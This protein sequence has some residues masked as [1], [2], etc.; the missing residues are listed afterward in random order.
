MTSFYLLSMFLVWLGTVKGA[1]DNKT[2][3]SP[4]LKI[5][6][7]CYPP[8]GCFKM[9][10][11][12]A[13]MK[14]L[15]QS[16]EQ[17]DTTF[18]LF[19][20]GQNHPEPLNFPPML[21]EQL[22]TSRQLYI[23]IHGFGHFP[24]WIVP[25]TEELLK[26]D[27]NVIVVDWT[28]GSRPPN[29]YQAASN[30]RVVGAMVAALVTDVLNSTSYTMKDITL[31]GFSLGCHV[32]GFAGKK[33]REP[34]L[35]RIVALDPAG[36]L[37]SGHGPKVRLAPTDAD[38]VQCIHTDGKG[39]MNGG[40]GTMQ[41]MGHVDFYANGGKV[42]LGCPRNVKEVII[43]L[44]S[45]NS[46]T[47]ETLTCSH[48]RAPMLYIETI[49]TIKDDNPCGFSAVQCKS[50][51]EWEMG[52]CFY[53]PLNRTMSLF[54]FGLSSL[55]PQGTFYFATRNHNDYS[56]PF[57]GKQYGFVV[58]PDRW[59]KGNLWL[60]VRYKDGSQEVIDLLTEGEEL[61]A[62]NEKVKV[63]AL[64]K[65]LDKETAVS[66]LY[67]KYASWIWKNGPD[68]WELKAFSVLDFNC[69]YFAMNNVTKVANKAMTEITWTET[70]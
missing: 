46:S 30:S 1:S 31:V 40:L 12:F 64:A 60:F 42:Q 63:A 34:K 7:V 41:P 55:M 4:P 65:P 39:F 56:A 45:L 54:G 9:S 19:T 44:W 51:E 68:E 50:T 52:K 28:K 37:F 43:D 35:S 49:K 23:L 61:H 10:A 14:V 59:I 3:E 18:W 6:K 69:T 47:F 8:Y 25:M 70:I 29:Y 53:C 16:P 22:N 32:C 20:P 24:I 11:K 5:D 13:H 58:Q 17:I 26:K 21:A 2:V 62:N 27:I 57:C 33:L 38:F 36:P 67:K 15:P 66:L 48:A